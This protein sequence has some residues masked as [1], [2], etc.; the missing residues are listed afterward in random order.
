[1]T[2]SSSL[3]EAGRSKSST[4]TLSAAE[5]SF[6]KDLIK[7]IKEAGLAINPKGTG[8]DSFI[9]WESKAVSLWSWDGRRFKSIEEKISVEVFDLNPKEGDG[10]FVVISLWLKDNVEVLMRDELR[11]W[12]YPDT[13]SLIIL[14]KDESK[15]F[16]T[17]MI[18]FDEGFEWKDGRHEVFSRKILEVVSNLD[19]DKWEKCDEGE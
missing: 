6:A 17:L 7:M 3:E 11:I 19:R 16:L 15:E 4:S 5:I 10:C 9:M 1:M 18:F 12:L 8:E 13:F 2:L 14:W